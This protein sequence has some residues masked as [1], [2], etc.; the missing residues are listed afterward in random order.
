MG[1]F[2]FSI[3][4]DK[5]IKFLSIIFDSLTPKGDVRKNL[6]EARNPSVTRR[7]TSDRP[8]W[9]ASGRMAGQS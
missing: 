2:F 8:R 7:K 6:N 1:E 3:P 9:G 5:G 4:F